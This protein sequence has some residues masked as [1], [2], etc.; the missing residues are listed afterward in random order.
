[1]SPRDGKIRSGNPWSAWFFLFCFQCT[2]FLLADRTYITWQFFSRNKDSL[3]PTAPSAPSPSL[4]PFSE[5]SSTSSALEWACDRLGAHLLSGSFRQ[6]SAE[7]GLGQDPEKESDAL[8][9]AH[10]TPP[11]VRWRTKKT[12]VGV[13]RRPD[14]AGSISTPFARRADPSVRDVCFG[15]R[16]AL[17]PSFTWTP[18]ARPVTA[19]RVL[20]Q[21]PNSVSELSGSREELRSV[22]SLSG[23]QS[24]SASAERAPGVSFL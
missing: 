8:S 15:A 21:G 18:C 22:S 23:G 11:P 3:T 5:K 24:N 1:M 9:S 17:D 14:T 2:G 20:I 4:R 7:K 13:A 16:D 6:S 10:P 19:H 12:F